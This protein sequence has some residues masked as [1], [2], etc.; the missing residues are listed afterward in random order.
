MYER[1]IKLVE[2]IDHQLPEAY[3]LPEPKYL[4]KT[5]E[6]CLTKE[7]ISVLLSLPATPEEV[8]VKLS[9]D[10]PTVAKIFKELFRKDFVVYKRVDSK[11]RC[12]LINGLFNLALPDRRARAKITKK[13]FFSLRA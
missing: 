3:G 12:V 1:F 8:C 6:T 7:E 2:E 10:I 13:T 11:L 9:G 4:P 5:L